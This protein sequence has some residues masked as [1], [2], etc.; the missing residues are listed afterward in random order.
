MITRHGFV[1]TH[2]CF[3]D[4]L[5]LYGVATQKQVEVMM[6]VMKVFC[7]NSREKVSLS[8]SRLLVSSNISHDQA[9]KLSN[10]CQIHLTKDFGKY[11]GAPLIH[12]QVTKMTYEDIIGK[13]Q[14]H[15]LV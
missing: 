1:L 8:K 14:G 13:I 5:M 6:N 11:L 15:L 3:M 12:G 10:F 7:D 2:I 4:D 9:T